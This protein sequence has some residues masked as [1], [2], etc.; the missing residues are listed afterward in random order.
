[1]KRKLAMKAEVANGMCGDY[2][3]ASS[4]GPTETLDLMFFSLLF[5][6]LIFAGGLFEKCQIALLQIFFG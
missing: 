2:R 1:M 5:G 6:T 4:V 3:L